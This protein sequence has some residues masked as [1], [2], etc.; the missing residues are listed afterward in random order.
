M[1]GLG[2][3]ACYWSTLLF[4]RFGLF[5][6]ILDGLLGLFP[7]SSLRAYRRVT[8]GVEFPISLR[9]PSSTAMLVAFEPSFNE[10][11]C[12]TPQLLRRP[13]FSLSSVSKIFHLAV[14]TESFS[15]HWWSRVVLMWL[16]CYFL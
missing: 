16:A 6:S 7:V 4:V 13:F 12:Q 11:R 15:M 1:L 14:L 9:Y 3:N 8:D 10:L 5:D 2:A